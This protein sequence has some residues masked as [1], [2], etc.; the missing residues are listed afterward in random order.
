MSRR[1]KDPLRDLTDAERQE[2]VQLS[3]SQ[4]G[5]GRRGHP[6]QDPAGRRLGRRLPGRRPL[7]RPPLRRRR[8]APRRPLQRR[9]H[10]RPDASPRRRPPAGPTARRQ[11]S[12]SRPRS[13][14]EPTPE[15]DGTATWSLATLQRTLRAASDGLPKVST[16]TI[17]LVLR[18]A[19]GELPAHP[20]L[21]PHRQ[22]PAPPQGRARGRHRPGCRLEKKL[23][24]TDFGGGPIGNRRGRRR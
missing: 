21:V 12:G 19:G 5:P 2:L 1:K 13:A 8:L 17:R 24:V 22:G 20:H 15:G 4:V 6:G 23:T 14:R 11:G 16:Y 3:R 18:E 7:G 10:R 9:G